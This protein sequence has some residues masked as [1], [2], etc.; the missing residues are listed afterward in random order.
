MTQEACLLLQIRL[1]SHRTNHPENMK[2]KMSEPQGLRTLLSTH[3]PPGYA[4]NLETKMSKPRSLKPRA[5]LTH[6]RR[7]GGNFSTSSKKPLPEL[8][9]RGVVC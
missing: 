4:E 8:Q 7:G 9:Y 2:S 6:Y 3:P 5:M 1:S